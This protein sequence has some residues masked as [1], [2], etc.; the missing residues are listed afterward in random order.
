[1]LTILH[2][3]H[4]DE[5][6]RFIQ[7]VLGQHYNFISVTDTPSA[8][9]YCAMIQPDLILVDLDLPDDDGR[10]LT[11]R[12]KMFMPQTPILN[13]ATD[14]SDQSQVQTLVADSDD[15]LLRPVTTGQLVE[16]LGGFYRNRPV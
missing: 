1:M 14:Q 10:E 6:Q 5:S 4:D 3:S 15:I 8:V 11:L 7:E 16:K 13:I 2:V 9:H 12:L